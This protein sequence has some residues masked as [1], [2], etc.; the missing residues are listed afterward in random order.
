MTRREQLDVAGCSCRRLRHQ[1]YF[2]TLISLGGVSA[3]LGPPPS[4]FGPRPTSLVLRATT[5]VVLSSSVSPFDY[6]QPCVSKT[7]ADGTMHVKRQKWLPILA[8]ESLAGWN[9][10]ALT[11]KTQDAGF[12][13]EIRLGLSRYAAR[14]S[15]GGGFAVISRSFTFNQATGGWRR[16]SESRRADIKR[17][18]DDRDSLSRREIAICVCVRRKWR[19]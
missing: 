12:A 15:H 9:L 11:I 10:L 13:A 17:R 18:S 3:S 7:N 4:L 1:S 5:S 2:A 8:S 19:A 6:G 16:D 14:K